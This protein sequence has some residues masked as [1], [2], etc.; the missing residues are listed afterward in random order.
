MHLWL[1]SHAGGGWGLGAVPWLSL[2]WFTWFFMLQQGSMCDGRI[3]T[4]RA[5]LHRAFL[6]LGSKLAHCRLYGILLV[7]T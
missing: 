2:T 7:K 5:K 1:C 6:G 4:D 3:L